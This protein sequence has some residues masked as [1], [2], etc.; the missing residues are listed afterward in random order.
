MAQSTFTVPISAVGN[1]G[2]GGS[3][4]LTATG[5]GT[6]ISLDIEGLAAGASAQAS[7]HAGTCEMPGASAAALPA[8]TADTSGKAAAS[9]SVLFRGTEDV[10]LSIIADGDHVILVS[11]ANQ[12]VA[13]GWIPQVE[14]APGMPRTGDAMPLSV[15]TGLFAL[16]L[17]ALAAGMRLRFAG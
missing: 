7:L 12:V 3:A 6:S 17:L 11:E 16:A 9:G 14:T 1:S 8:L 15:A 2:V 4:V 10:A 13:C 5:G